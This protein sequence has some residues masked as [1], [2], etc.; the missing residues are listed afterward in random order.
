M[1]PCSIGMIWVKVN[2]VNLQSF[3]RSQAYWVQS[4][5]YLVVYSHRFVDVLKLLVLDH[6]GLKV[7]KSSEYF[8]IERFT[9]CRVHSKS[10][11]INICNILVYVLQ[12]S[13]LKPILI[14]DDFQGQSPIAA[15][16][17]WTRVTHKYK[18]EIITWYFE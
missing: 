1:D 13:F 18:I 15:Q 3:L 9:I 11:N 6:C 7:Y 4:E 8:N 14:S 2:E 17:E 16:S 10:F 5:T 12:L